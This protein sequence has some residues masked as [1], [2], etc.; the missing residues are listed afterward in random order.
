M[1]NVNSI[2]SN[3]YGNTQSLYGSKNVLTGL[4][5]GMDTE[6]M[7]QNSVAGYQTKIASLQQS[8]TKIEW[9]Q[10]AYRE[11]TDQMNS[12]LQ[13]YTS[14]T[15]KTNLASN[16]FFTSASKT[17]TQGANAAAITATGQTKSDIQIDAVTQLATAARYAVDASALGVKATDQAVG[18]AIDWNMQK[19]VGQINGSITLKYGSQDIE[20]KFDESDVDIKTPGK[21]KEAIEKKLAD[22][23]IKAKDGS[24]VKANTLIR[25]KTNGN[26]FTFEVNRGNSD[27]DGSS[28]YINGVSG[29]VT[30]MLGA[31]RPTS[32]T[33]EEKVKNTGFTVPDMDALV[34]TPTMA[35]YLKDKKVDVTL[36]GVT[37]SVKIGDLADADVTVGLS[38]MKGSEAIA[39]L[40][41]E[42]TSDSYKQ[43]LSAALT[44][45]LKSDLQASI[46]KAFGSG[47]VT[48]SN[49]DGALRF[50]VAEGSGSTIKVSSAAG[51][52]LGIGKGGVSNYF[53]TA[54]TLKD[55]LGEDW[56]NENARIA[57][58]GDS[59]SFRTTGSGDDI[60]YFDADSN[61]VAQ[62]TDGNWYRVNDNGKFL[63][64]MEIN[65][66]RVGQFTEDTAFENV[67]TAINSDADVGVNVSYSNLTGEFVFNARETGAGGKISFDSA[68]AKKLFE[69]DGVAAEDSA[70]F[71]KG[72]DAVINATVNGKALTLT[73]SSN[74]VNMDGLNVTFKKTFNT[75]GAGEAVTFKTSSDSDKVVDTVKEFVDDINKL[76]QS[77]HDAYATAPLKKSTSQKNSS[78][79]EPL[80]EEDKADM[81]ES[82]I[83]A[84]EEK[85]KTGLLFGD[86]DLSQLYSSLL[87]TLQASGA[88]R[89]DMEAIGLTTTFSGGVTQ[90]SLNEDKLRSALD[91][92]PDKVRGVFTKTKEGGAKSNGLMASFKTTMT[93][94]ASTSLGS[95]GILV[96][97]AGTKLSAI[98]L[99]NNNLQKQID[100]INT[101]IEQWQTRLS[102]KVDYYTRQF[103]Q[104]E[105][106][107][108]TMNN[109]SSMLADLMGG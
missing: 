64:S 73:R 16:A 28:V 9:K 109:Q 44:D 55:L 71:A 90:F 88:D 69:A 99:M 78:G 7:I 23:S 43:E 101:Q 100:N 103:T 105:K 54:N 34:K 22:V 29:N 66:K 38:T 40:N 68:L 33:V 39:L 14:Y 70:G 15:S 97:K 81:S 107:M 59:A 19:E 26:A 35:E 61:R 52:A 41:D 80:T 95:P 50:D 93:N 21:L 86:T 36:D 85:A 76:M 63:Y 62:G 60:K 94:Y 87:S 98:S 75:E 18:S 42:N 92:D 77:V 10:D 13:K 102:D 8:Q 49:A 108:S 53:N 84:Y 91:S 24:S 45:A 6:T 104:L 67:L 25:V 72:A 4:A 1:A 32:S 79:Y 74:T 82:A 3:S 30:T 5:S 56:L 96:R 51:E 46:D 58:S 83:T 12:I 48:V 31:S 37:K 89:M 65:G 57:A 106:L 11:I 20:L 2:S 27:D 47:K 17:E